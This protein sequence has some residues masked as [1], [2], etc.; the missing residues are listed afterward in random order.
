LRH[1]VVISNGG[2]VYKHKSIF[3]AYLG[4]RA[5]LITCTCI[6]GIHCLD[7]D[8]VNKWV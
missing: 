1:T 7:Q 8:V 5:V 6:K 3:C 2:I 4:H